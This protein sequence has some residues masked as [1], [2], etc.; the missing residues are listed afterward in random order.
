MSGK[1]SETAEAA[2]VRKVLLAA[3]PP[4]VPPSFRTIIRAHS[5]GRGKA[6]QITADLVMVD[7]MPATVRLRQWEHGW[8]HQ[9]TAMPGGAL[10]FEDGAWVRVE[11]QRAAA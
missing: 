11:Q 7:G 10:S 6:R 8:S 1:Q 5:E 2:V 3:L 9:F 4:G